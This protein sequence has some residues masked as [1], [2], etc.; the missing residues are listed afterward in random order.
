MFSKLKMARRVSE[1][2]VVAVI[3]RE[4]LKEP[5]GMW[6]GSRGVTQARSGRKYSGRNIGRWDRMGSYGALLVLLKILHIQIGLMS[7]GGGD[8]LMV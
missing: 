4:A 1:L 7:E 5:I 2:N 6:K 8:T 3:V